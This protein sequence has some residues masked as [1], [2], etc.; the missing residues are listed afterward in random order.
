M[1][2][3]IGVRSVDFKIEASGYGV[4]NWNGTVAVTGP[5][6]KEINNHSVPKLRGFSNKSGKVKEESGYEYKISALDVD[7]EKTPVYISQN[8][9]RHHLFRSESFNVT[10]ELSADDATKLLCSPVGLLRGYAI[11]GSQPLAKKSPLLLE[12]FVEQTGN[13]NFEQMGK[14]GSRDQKTTMYSKTTMG[15]T[16]Y[17]GYGSISIEEL[18]FI[19]LDNKFGRSAVKSPYAAV[20][21]EKLAGEITDFLKKI[22]F[23]GKMNP[24]AKYNE[25]Y[26]RNGSIMDLGEAGIVINS[27]GCA[28]LVRLML[29][30]LESLYI[31]QSKGW[32]RVDT[33]TVDY[34]DSKKPMRVR[35]KDSQAVASNPANPMAGY[36][37]EGNDQNVSKS[38]EL[39]DKLQ[40][41]KAKKDTKTSKKQ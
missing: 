28:L 8:C 41:N 29:D 4:V 11:S 3:V 25:C 12:D 2:K 1:N 30:K 35:G 5:D 23:D 33:V 13:G 31:Q 34:N 20:D 21:G 15:E 7:L 38:K 37:R 10:A 36:Y 9:L 39:D 16:K 40:S 22:D 19:S 24:E 26:V 14:S 18:S 27:D 17:V 6:G 32:M